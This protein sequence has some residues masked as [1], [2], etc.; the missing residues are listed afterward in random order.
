M[1][2]IPDFKQNR[3][4]YFNLIYS[5]L[6]VTFELSTKVNSG[7]IVEVKNENGDVIASFEAKDSFKTLIVSNEKISDETLSLYV[8]GEKVQ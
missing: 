8:D 7:S 4:R 5:I 1:L 6:Y 2:I 3:N